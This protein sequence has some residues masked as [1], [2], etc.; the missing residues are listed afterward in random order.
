[1][2]YLFFILKMS[3]IKIRVLFLKCMDNKYEFLM[4]LFIVIS[5][6]LFFDNSVYTLICTIP[7]LLYL[8]QHSAKSAFVY[9]HRWQPNDLVFWDNR[10][11][12]HQTIRDYG[13]D[14]PRHMHRT[15]IRG[16]KPFL[17]RVSFL[18]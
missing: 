12:I 10:C 14:T 9:R 3:G 5:I 18:E 8:F 7:L 1:M 4:T 15:T 2:I 16:D 13:A 11:T 6:H 17:S